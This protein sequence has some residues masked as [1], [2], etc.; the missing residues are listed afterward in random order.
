[1]GAALVE[2]LYDLWLFALRRDTKPRIEYRPTPRP[3]SA[4]TV[5]EP[6]PAPAPVSLDL[7]VPPISPDMIQGRSAYVVHDAVVCLSRPT[8]DFDTVVGMLDYA[9]RVAVDVIEGEFAHIITPSMSGWV[10]VEMLTDDLSV[11]M[12][13]LESGKV[14]GSQ[15]EETKK[16][17]KYI[18]DEALGSALALP[19]QGSEYLLFRLKRAGTK[20]RWS[21]VRPRAAGKW[22]SILRGQG[23]VTMGIEPKTGA[24][25][26]YSGG[27][28]QSFLGYVESV[29]PNRS[30]VISSVGREREAEYR[31]ETF[32]NE[33]WREWRPVFISFT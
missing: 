27:E 32:S 30:I 4:D 11:V 23:G 17:R 2:V 7:V 16:L 20:V 14:Y 24:V 10:P 5:V 26:E 28:T 12:P 6:A 25:L 13:Q 3:D 31:E 29:K 22:Q 8:F 9:E 15:S 33:Q 21:D 18:D 19:L 1:M